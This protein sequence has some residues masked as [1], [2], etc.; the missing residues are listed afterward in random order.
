M[1]I[2]F[3]MDNTLAD[4]FGSTI[5]PGIT[6]LLDRLS[7]DGHRLSLWTS[8]SKDRA[9]GILKDLGL[10]KYFKTCVFR[11]DYDPKNEDLAKDIRRIKGDFL[12]DDDPKQ[13]KYVKSI[14]K[15]GFLINPYRKGGNPDDDEL[16]NLYKSIGKS[17]GRFSFLF[18]KK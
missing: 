2:V 5:R 12:V 8:S 9:E 14:G 18:K 15:S 7:S 6:D 4:E 3:D 1:H 11:E 16:K 17:G 13:I 10:R